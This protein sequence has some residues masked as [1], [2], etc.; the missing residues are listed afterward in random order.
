MASLDTIKSTL[1]AMGFAPDD[2]KSGDWSKTYQ[3]YNH[4]LRVSLGK[5]PADCRIDFGT[6]IKDN[7]GRT[8]TQNLSQPESLVVL[9]CVDR[10]PEL[11]Y[12]ECQEC[13]QKPS[14]YV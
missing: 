2:G 6:T 8:T 1:R 10:L 14:R 4:I 13:L 5:N 9:E 12:T 11:G 7:A 3:S